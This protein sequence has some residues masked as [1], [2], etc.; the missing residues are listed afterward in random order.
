MNK[1]MFPPMQGWFDWELLGI[2]ENYSVIRDKESKLI[3]V[4]ERKSIRVIFPVTCPNCKKTADFVGTRRG[5]DYH[6]CSKCKM[7]IEIE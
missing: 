5:T 3:R 1:T 4:L 2:D 7:F 6:I